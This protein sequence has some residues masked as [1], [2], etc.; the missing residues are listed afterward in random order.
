MHV[1]D[2]LINDRRLQLES[3]NMF[4]RYRENGIPKMEVGA[5]GQIR[6]STSYEIQAARLAAKR[7]TMAS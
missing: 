3:G 1:S 2:Q 5:T 4:S 7:A 6:L